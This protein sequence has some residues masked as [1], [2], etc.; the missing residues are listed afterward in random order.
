MTTKKLPWWRTDTYDGE[1]AIPE[2]MREHAGPNGLALV[3]AY[4]DGRTQAGW[5]LERKVE[6]KDGGFEKQPDFMPR[7]L[8]N[9]FAE[10]RA[11]H[12]FENKGMPF[13]FVM[14]S[15]QLV[16]I[17]ID[18]KNGGLEHAKKLGALPPTLAETSKSGDGY[19]L[20][21][22][23]EG[24]VWDV[25]KGAAGLSDRIG[26]ETGVDFRA[27]G[28]V[29]HHPQQRWNDRPVAVFPAHLVEILQQREQRAA[30]SSDRIT[31]VLANNDDLEVLMMQN[32][33]EAELE[34]PIAP[35]KRNN[36]LFAIGSQ[37]ATA[38]V[39]D[40]QDKVTNRACEVG[41]DGDEIDKLVSNI[42]RYTA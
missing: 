35:G 1:H 20:F 22:L 31:K 16:C 41:L 13:A 38:E 9:E 39:P 8:K 17:D 2:Q 25:S 23:L 33:L 37:M 24:D 6:L 34:K 26:I 42:E 40:W 36:T 4:P 5:G 14:R 29:Y 15:M 21:Y 32:E 18:G 11:V 30:A 19:H 12:A 27:T 28:C 7:Y 10:R 3:K